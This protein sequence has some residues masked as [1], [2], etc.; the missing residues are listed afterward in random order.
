MGL[1]LEL[2]TFLLLY[3]MDNEDM[4]RYTHTNYNASVQSNAS[5]IISSRYYS[6]NL[7]HIAELFIDM[8]CYN[9]KDYFA[10]ILCM[11][12]NPSDIIGVL[13]GFRKSIPVV[14]NYP[15]LSYPYNSYEMYL[16]LID[17]ARSLQ[18]RNLPPSL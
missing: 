13:Y 1:E 4:I 15:I 8:P 16:P 6:H 9:N 5:T 7:L 18:W 14:K 3:K 12:Q 10:N 11:A 17:H 2:N